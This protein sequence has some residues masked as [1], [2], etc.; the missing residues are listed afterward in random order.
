VDE[1]NELEASPIA[2][3]TGAAALTTM[4]ATLGLW[5]LLLAGP[6]GLMLG[7]A[8]LLQAASRPAPAAAP[9]V[10]E[11][12]DARAAAGEFAQRLV[13]V[14]LT[15]PRGQE[16][17]LTSLVPVAATITLPEVAFT[18][19]NPTISSIR[20]VDGV[21]SVTVAADV[22][23][24]RNTP[25][26]RFY[27]VPVTVDAGVVTAL[28]LPAPVTGPPVGSTS[29]LGYRFQVAA[30]GPVAETAAEFLDAYLAGAS[31]VTRY[32]SP[33]APASISAITPAPYTAVKVTDL[34]GDT[35][36]DTTRVPT[37]GTQLRV[38][39]SAALTATAKQQTSVTYALT[40]R[41]RA[42]RWE[43]LAIDPAPAL[44]PA[45]SPAASPADPAR[46]PMISPPPRISPLPTAVTASAI[47]TTP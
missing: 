15:T 38:L 6:A 19:S 18:V 8:A 1:P 12:G 39:V 30:N 26:R 41:A 14:W 22:A 16:D 43:V 9:A 35:D 46:S 7:G 34:R 3:W 5:L 23:D 44:I 27:L 2:A 29:R 45:P 25:V 28:S 24:Q 37:E 33:E 21:W 40:L 42:G 10:Q 20:R 31:D 36:L 32:V 13:T 4:A 17:K 11:S 47:P